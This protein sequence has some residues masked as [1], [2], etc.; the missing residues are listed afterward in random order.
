MGAPLAAVAVTTA[1]IIGL[2]GPAPAAPPDLVSRLASTATAAEGCAVIL[3]DESPAGGPSEGTVRPGEAMSIDL[4]WG[5]DWQTDAP[6]EVL[7]CTAVDGHLFADASTRVAG[8]K[9]DG[10]FVHRFGVP[11]G[12]PEGATLCE[13]GAVIGRN[14][15]GTARVQTISAEC[16]T[17]ESAAPLKAKTATTPP[18]SHDVPPPAAQTPVAPAPAPAPTTAATVAPAVA[19]VPPAP[20]VPTVVAGAT[21]TRTAAVETL[22]RTGGADHAVTAAAGAFLLAGGFAVGFGRPFRRLNP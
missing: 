8:L 7:G 16:L 14:A 5:Q 22:P 3:S 4:V 12:M 1:A 2:A 6:V 21:A 19:A 13:A 9:N 11:E 15:G 17:V 18:R 10:R 20:P